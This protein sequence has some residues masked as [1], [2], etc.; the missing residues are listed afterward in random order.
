MGDTRQIAD[1]ENDLA[2]EGNF[3]ADNAADEGNNGAD[4]AADEGNDAANEGN[5]AG[6]E[7]NAAAAEETDAGENDAAAKETDTVSHVIVT[8]ARCDSS[9][10]DARCS[11]PGH[12]AITC[13]HLTRVNDGSCM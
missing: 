9:I 11:V 4:N 8:A 5:D 13:R 6:D 7:G 2:D 10:C 1:E 3:D 12:S